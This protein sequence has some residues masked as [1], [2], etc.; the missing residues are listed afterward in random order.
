MIEFCAAVI[1]ALA[2]LIY[3][4]QKSVAEQY[5]AAAE[6]KQIL[7]QIVQHRKRLE[8]GIRSIFRLFFPKEN[9]YT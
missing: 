6:V 9:A 7:L 8:V 3:G 1:S 2:Q 5:G 4:I